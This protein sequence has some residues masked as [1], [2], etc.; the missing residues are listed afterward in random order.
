MNK[1]QP[2]WARYLVANLYENNYHS[3]ISVVIGQSFSPLIR[4]AAVWVYLTVLDW[5]DI[6]NDH[7]KQSGMNNE[8]V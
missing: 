5:F 2:M 3:I 1:E 4:Q 8:H 6:Y 7:S